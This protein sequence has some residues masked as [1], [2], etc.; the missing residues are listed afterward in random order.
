MPKSS[1]VPAPAQ[2]D[3]DASGVQRR[4]E[5]RERLIAAAV[6]VYGEVGYRNATVRAICQR[7]RLTERYF[8]EAFGSNEKLLVEAA[9]MLAGQTLAR[10]IALKDATAGDADAVTLRVLTDYY[11]I[12]LR[13]ASKARVF[14]L[15]FR[16]I[17]ATADAEFE[18]ILDAF[19]TL[20]VSIRDPRGIGPAA[21]DRLLR[22]GIIGGI[23]QI[24]LAWIESGYREPPETVARAAA[25]ICS[26]ADPTS[27]N[28]P[29]LA[30]Q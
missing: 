15:E 20:L 9:A 22:R 2:I 1:A 21:N 5:R 14:T 7:A 4:A 12:Q 29:P 25:R 11:R 8:Y 18:R 16:G 23:L 6:D 19:S 24:T 13:E 28:V 3:R 17:C 10:M 27:A 30:E 26:L